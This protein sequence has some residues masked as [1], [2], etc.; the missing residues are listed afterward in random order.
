M[1]RFT[2]LL[3]PSVGG[4]PI[5]S[6]PV[7]PPPSY[8]S[9]APLDLLAPHR[10]SPTLPSPPGAPH[11]APSPSSRACAP[12]SQ[13]LTLL[14]TSLSY[15][16]IPNVLSVSS[17]PSPPQDPISRPFLSP[18]LSYS[19]PSSSF[20]APFLQFHSQ[21]SVFCVFVHFVSKLPSHFSFDLS[22]FGLLNLLLPLFMRF[23]V[24]WG[25]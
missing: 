12:P 22:F 21:L 13:L 20:P 10:L 5:P 19:F 11:R 15:P 7:A 6:S 16:G 18:L 23:E 3:P 24:V 8:P 4:V 1:P 14:E 17:A 25:C 2:S 9:V